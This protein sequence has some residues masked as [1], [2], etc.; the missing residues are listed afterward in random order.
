MSNNP[1]TNVFERLSKKR[2]LGRMLP[3]TKKANHQQN[4]LMMHIFRTIGKKRSTSRL[5]MIQ[6]VE[7][8]LIE[9]RNGDAPS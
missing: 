8:Q 2:L 9:D 5:K 4:K 1:L 3:T 7:E 6:E